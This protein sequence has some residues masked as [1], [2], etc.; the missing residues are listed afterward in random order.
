MNCH[1]ASFGLNQPRPYL[2]K[3]SY[4]RVL[5]TSKQLDLAAA[6][7]P[8]VH[9]RALMMTKAFHLFR[10]LLPVG[11]SALQRQLL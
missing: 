3:A 2:A 9:D 4:W 8:E 6:M 7:A 1:R 10:R 11:G 5:D